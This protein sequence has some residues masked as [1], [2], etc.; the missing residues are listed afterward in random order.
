MSTIT[1]LTKLTI[2]SYVKIGGKKYYVTVV[3]QPGNPQL[4]KVTQVTIGSK[5]KKL[6]A[7]A[8]KSVNKLSVVNITAGKLKTIEKGAFS[9][10][11]EN[12]VFNIKGTKNQ[13][14]NVKKLL[15]A[16]GVSEKATFINK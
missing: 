14:E 4:S 10:T 2:P 6:T 15:I 1:D 5:V 11:D 3:D 12:T 8:F 9:M 13:F 7:N 16:S